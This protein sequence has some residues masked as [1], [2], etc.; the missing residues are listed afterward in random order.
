ME[1]SDRP[2]T[3]PSALAQRSAGMAHTAALGIGSLGPIHSL[4]H[5]QGIKGSKEKGAAIARRALI[6]LD[7]I[8]RN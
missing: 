2:S 1:R 6:P 3:A 4:V 5:R 8:E 7:G